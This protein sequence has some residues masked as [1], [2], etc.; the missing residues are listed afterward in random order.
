LQLIFHKDLIGNKTENLESCDR[1]QCAWAFL[2]NTETTNKQ[3]KVLK[4]LS[5]KKGGLM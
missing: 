4:E 3:T 1:L 5:L 2:K